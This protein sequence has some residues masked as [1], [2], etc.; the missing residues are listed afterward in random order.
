MSSCLI[1]II[2]LENDK[3]IDFKNYFCMAGRILRSACFLHSFILKYLIY[4]FSSR[5]I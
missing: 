2:L 4:L 3:N 1:N 5:D